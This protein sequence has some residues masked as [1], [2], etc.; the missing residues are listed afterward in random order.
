MIYED[1]QIQLC[2][3]LLKDLEDL[4]QK[5]KQDSI[6]SPGEARTKR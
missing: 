3:I 5:T 1:Q 2:I 6:K 4:K